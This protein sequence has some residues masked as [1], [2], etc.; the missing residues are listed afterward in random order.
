MS[1]PIERDPTMAYLLGPDVQ[2]GKP[3]GGAVL[4]PSTGEHASKDYYDGASHHSREL[5]FWTPGSSDADG[6]ILDSKPTLDA[7]TRD[8]IRNDAYVQAGATLH[9]DHIVGSIYT[10][11]AKPDYVALGLDSEWADEFSEEVEAKFTLAAESPN[12]WFDASRQNTFTEM[13]RL[14]VGVILSGGEL[15]AS[16]EWIRQSGRPFNTAI[17]MIDADR[18]ST[19][20]HLLETTRLRAGVAK[21]RYGAPTGYYVREAHPAD[22]T[23]PSVWKWRYIPAYKPWGR[24]QFIHIYETMRPGQTR[25]VSELASILKEGRIAK[26]FREVALQRAIIDASFAASIESEMPTEAVFAAL[27]NG[28]LSQDDVASAIQRYAVGYLQSVNEFSGSKGVKIDGVQIPHFF[29][30]TKL[31]V[32]PV[33]NGG[34]LGSEFEQSLLRY[35]AAGLGVS[36]EQLS[37]DFTN[38]NYS[39]ARAAINETHKSMMAKKKMGA[40]RFATIVYMLWLEEMIANGEITSLPRNAPNFW[41]GINREAYCACQWIGASRG[42]IDELKET[43]AAVLRLKYNLSTYEYEAARLGLDYRKL[44]RQRGREVKEMKAENILPDSEDNMMNAASGS[45]Q[46]REAKDEKDDGSEDNTDA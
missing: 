31:N 43:Q 3:V 8:S 30:G 44:F 29:P 10:L 36:Y 23:N 39:S 1:R 26:K 19:P 24:M 25:G 33:G 40:D 14:A 18:L 37:K 13:V 38:T 6:E 12:N 11:N 27:G 20:P 41:E 35:L 2:A 5:A 46:E 42:Q 45:V 34:P 22:W 21:D 17:Q 9:K 7:R 15:T 32:R 4:P 16:V 28:A